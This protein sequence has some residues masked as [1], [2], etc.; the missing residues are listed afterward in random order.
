MLQVCGGLRR[1][2]AFMFVNMDVAVLGQLAQRQVTRGM[3]LATPAVPG[4]MTPPQTV[5]GRLGAFI[6]MGDR[7]RRVEH[8]ALTYTG[9]YLMRPWQVECSLMGAGTLVFATTSC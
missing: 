9:T 6:W 2:M 4:R 7:L 1:L 3:Q 5:H 8:L